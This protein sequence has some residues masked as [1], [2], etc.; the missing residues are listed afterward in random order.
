ML[1]RLD[2]TIR[3]MD[4]VLLIGIVLLA[5]SLASGIIGYIQVHG[6]FDLLTFLSDFYANISAELGSIAITVIVIDS[7]N[8]RR[9]DHELKARLVREARSRDNSTA[10]SAVDWLRAEGLLKGEK[11][12]LRKASL[13]DANLANALLTDVN[14]SQSDMNNANLYRANVSYSDLSYILMPYGNLRGANFK[15]SKLS[16]A[17][18]MYI[19]AEEVELRHTDLTNSSL[20]GA[21]LRGANLQ[22][23]NLTRAQMDKA[24][25]ERVNMEFANLTHAILK[26][27]SFDETTI[28]PDGT[29]Y[30]PELGLEQLARFTDPNH[31]DFWQPDWVKEQSPENQ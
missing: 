13:W 2:H 6:A 31:P 27:T 24:R 18:L 8:K 26:D 9:S 12:L 23:A 10:V 22:F 29:K 17:N 25:L 7:F 28:L 30:D 19:Q 3:H 11:S 15:F 20:E 5:L 14:L 21:D 16:N 1:R 4:S